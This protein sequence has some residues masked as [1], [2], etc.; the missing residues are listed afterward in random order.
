MKKGRGKVHTLLF[1]LWDAL[2]KSLKTG[3]WAREMAMPV[4]VTV[5]QPGNLSS[6][7]EPR[8]RW[9]E[10]TDSTKQSDPHMHTMIWRSPYP[11]PVIIHKHNKFFK[12][13]I[14]DMHEWYTWAL[15]DRE[16]VT[17]GGT[18]SRVHKGKF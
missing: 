9:K 14:N 8:W 15:K 13:K 12:K 17:L 18:A 10:R 6:I 4:K 5:T 2:F 1:S 11:Q 7:L 16:I 3:I